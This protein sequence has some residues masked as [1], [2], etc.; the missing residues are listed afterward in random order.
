MPST[1]RL[2]DAAV[3]YSVKANA[4]PDLLRHLVEL[5]C[6]FD[7]ASPGEV[8]ACLAAWADPG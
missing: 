2:P 7:V 6:G 1:R 5:G 4:D 3:Y 8:D